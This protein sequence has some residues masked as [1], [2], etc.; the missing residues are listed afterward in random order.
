MDQG[1][2]RDD[3]GGPIESG[4]CRSIGKRLLEAVDQRRHGLGRRSGHAD[5]GVVHGVEGVRM[6]DREAHIRR[7]AREERG[8]RGRR[9]RHRGPHLREQIGHAA[10][11]DRLEQ[12]EP[13]REVVIRGVVADIGG[14]GDL[15]QADVG[16]GH[17]FEQL[18]R[19]V[20]Q[21][22]R[23]VAVVVAVLRT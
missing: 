13:I 9:I 1:P 19:G 4:G 2:Q 10:L 8:A 15:A 23:Q 14:A 22:A 3:V 21:R 17:P 12:A 11:G 16:R 18:H 5:R 20:F 6:L 7:A